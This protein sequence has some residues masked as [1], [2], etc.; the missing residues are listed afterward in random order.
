MAVFLL[1]NVIF[2]PFYA[3]Y[4]RVCQYAKGFL[5]RS[6][7]SGSVGTVILKR[8]PFLFFQISFIFRFFLNPYLAHNLYIVVQLVL[9]MD[10]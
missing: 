2:M 9:H 1:V 5:I 3:C 7:S 10:H 4:T 8:L 6:S